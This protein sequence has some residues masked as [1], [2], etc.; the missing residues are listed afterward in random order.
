MKKF[1]CLFIVGLALTSLQVLAQA[2]FPT[3]LVN[4][5][6]YPENPIF[7]GTNLETWDKQ[8]RERGFILKEGPKY[9]LWFT[10]YSP[11]STTKFLG[12]ATSKDGI[13]FERFYS[14]KDCC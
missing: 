4:F 5:K 11:A 14:R 9:H 8:I 2:T 12:Y 10:G 13:H 6:A 3:E 1:S 7:T